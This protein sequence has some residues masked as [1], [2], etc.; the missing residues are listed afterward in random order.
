MIDIH[1]HLEHMGNDAEKEKII[2]EARQ[3]MTALITSVAD[4]KDLDEILALRDRHKGFVFVSLGFHPERIEKYKQQEIDEYI[5]KIMANKKNIVAI[6]EVGLDYSWIKE[7]SRREE[8]KEIFLQ[9][10]ELA[11]ELRLPMV[12]HGRNEPGSSDCTRDILEILDAAKTDAVL[13]CFSGSETNLR[14]AL[15]KEY[16]ISF[17][18]LVCKSDKH[19]RFAKIVPLERMLLETDAP[20]L[21]PTSREMINRPWLIEESAKAIAGIKGITKDEVLKMTEGNA[22]GVFG[23]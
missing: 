23:L 1:C 8:S 21:H 3:K 2:A 18:T 19:K 20:W 6:G 16:W 12:I 10:I 11:N 13:H 7:P 22:R 9:F 17:A 14:E 5:E 15:K 4:P